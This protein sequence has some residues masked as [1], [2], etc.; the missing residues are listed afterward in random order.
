[1]KRQIIHNILSNINDLESLNLSDKEKIRYLCALHDLGVIRYN[2]LSAANYYY[3]WYEIDL[4]QEKPNKNN[5]TANL[6]DFDLTFKGELFR[7]E[8]DKNNN[9]QW[10]YILLEIEEKIEND[11]QFRLDNWN[12][13]IEMNSPKQL[14]LNL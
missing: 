4:S 8:L 6:K 7:R 2:K 12:L 10:N 3:W 13:L 11:F 5:W 1:M 14:N 9:L